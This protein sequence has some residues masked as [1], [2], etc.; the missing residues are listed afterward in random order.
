M[1][2]QRKLLHKIL[3]ISSKYN[4]L[5]LLVGFTPIQF[6]PIIDSKGTN[7]T[8]IFILL[9]ITLMLVSV[10]LIY[11][12]IKK[13][14][15]NLKY[16]IV[17]VILLFISIDGIFASIYFYIYTNSPCNFNVTNCLKDGKVL[18]EYNGG[19]KSL[20]ETN[21]LMLLLS[22]MESDA[23][24]SLYAIQLFRKELKKIQNNIR[25][26]ISPYNGKHHKIGKD[27]SFYF[28]RKGVLTIDHYEV[29]CDLI[30]IKTTNEKIC[31]NDNFF[32]P[33]LIPHPIIQELLEIKD[34]ENLI[35]YIDIIIDKLK[36]CQQ[37]Q[38]DNMNELLL[39]NADLGFF[40]FFYFSTISITTTG[41]GDITPN[42]RIVRIIVTIQTL[43]G[44]FYI[45]FALLLFT[46]KGK[47]NLKKKDSHKSTNSN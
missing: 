13:D 30:F 14:I 41:Y 31:L 35:N 38:F 24:T 39:N 44:I 7:V 36:V 9:L 6:V 46:K 11:F 3:T 29:I 17:M 40:D 32:Y 27:Y 18:N 10:W 2:L 25:S 47:K 19:F 28:S 42:S 37:V 33:T 8:Y 23:D 43:F 1:F 5:F 12:L 34:K 15:K 4:F 21:K 45:G 22:Q 16:K 26:L 20:Q